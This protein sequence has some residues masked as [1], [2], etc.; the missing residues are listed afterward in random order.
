MHM[1]HNLKEQKTAVQRKSFCSLVTQLPLPEEKLHASLSKSGPGQTCYTTPFHH[2]GF[3]KGAILFE[4]PGRLPSPK[5]THTRVL[6]LFLLNGLHKALTGS[7]FWHVN[8]CSE[9]HLKDERCGQIEYLPLL[10]FYNTFIA[11]GLLLLNS[12]RTRA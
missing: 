3:K 9:K 6:I 4:L 8:R 10:N 2:S 12:C 7:I 11:T 1:I 5:Q